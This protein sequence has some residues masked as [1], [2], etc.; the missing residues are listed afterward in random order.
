MCIKSSA[1]QNPGEHARLVSPIYPQTTGSCLSF[2]YNMCGSR[3]GTL[4][5]YLAET[6]PITPY[7]IIFHK[8]GNQVDSC[9]SQNVFSKI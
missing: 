7:Q 6:G 5:V 4:T 2:Y 9:L 8:S 3:M 1:P